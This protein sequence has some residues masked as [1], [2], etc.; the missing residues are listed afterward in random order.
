MIFKINSASTCTESIL[1]NT[2]PKRPAPKRPA[3]TSHIPIAWAMKRKRRSELVVTSRIRSDSTLIAPG[4][5]AGTSFVVPLFR[6]IIFFGLGVIKSQVAF[7]GSCGDVTEFL[8]SVRLL[9]LPTYRND[10]IRFGRLNREAPLNNPMP[11]SY[12]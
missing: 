11:L 9:G 3:P 4:M 10:R 7:G 6:I 5:I 1:I 8:G 12:Y 2:A